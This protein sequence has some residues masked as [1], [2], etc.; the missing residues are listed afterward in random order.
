MVLDFGSRLSCKAKFLLKLHFKV[1]NVFSVC[2]CLVMSVMFVIMSATV[3]FFS[4]QGHDENGL[5][6]PISCT[7]FIR[8][9]S[10]IKSRC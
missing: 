8:M 10:S 4:E 1:R 7:L 3:G 6:L 2:M 9:L 5:L